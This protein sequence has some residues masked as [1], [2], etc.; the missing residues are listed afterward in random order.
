MS[1]AHS[2][3]TRPARRAAALGCAGAALLLHALLLGGWPR[4]PAARDARPPAVQVRQIVPA[5]MPALSAP[6]APVPAP[7]PMQQPPGRAERP[8]AASPPPT[9]AAEAPDAPEAAAAP[10]PPAGAASDTALP[11]YVTRLAPAATL[12]YAVTRGARRGSAQLRWRHDGASYELALDTRVG[13]L[14]ALGSAST[15]AI[16]AHGIA[17]DRYVESRRGRERR[18]ANFEREQGLIRYSGPAV[19]H[20]LPP[21]AQDRLSWLLQLGGVLAADARFEAAGSQ[22]QLFVAGSRGDAEVWTFTSAGRETVELAD[23]SAIAA[24]RFDREPRRPYDTRA[25]VW[26]APAHHHLPVRVR[27]AVVRPTAPGDSGAGIELLLQSTP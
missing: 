8:A 25:S 22:V 16:D 14:P 24:V 1:L 18:A 27:L 7:K 21:G 20:E 12:D 23:G 10:P 6:P 15:G 5:A 26:L 4:A 13:A 11:V 3:G 17:P 2:P 19:E 9:A